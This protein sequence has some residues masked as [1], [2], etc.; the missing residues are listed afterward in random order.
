METK[1]AEVIN[2]EYRRK[3]S[4]KGGVPMK[5]RQRRAVVDT[6]ETSIGASEKKEQ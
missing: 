3:K 1:E 2:T 6:T 5:E 4:W